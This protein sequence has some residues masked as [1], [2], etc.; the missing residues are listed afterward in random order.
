MNLGPMLPSS[1]LTEFMSTNERVCSCSVLF[2]TAL[3]TPEMALYMNLTFEDDGL[4]AYI[5]MLVPPCIWLFHSTE[6][7]TSA[8]SST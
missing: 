1:C 6:F 3:F 4:R 7:S 5:G 8:Y 2:H